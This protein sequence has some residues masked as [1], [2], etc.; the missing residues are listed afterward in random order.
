[1]DWFTHFDFCLTYKNQSLTFIHLKATNPVQHIN[2][3]MKKSYNVEN[4][5]D[6][7]ISHKQRRRKAKFC[8]MDQPNLTFDPSV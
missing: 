6:S 2:V 5:L 7:V 4:V 3:N 8:I 1:M